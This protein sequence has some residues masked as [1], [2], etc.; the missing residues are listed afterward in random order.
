MQTATFAQ[1][2][3][4]GRSRRIRTL[5][6]WNAP[7]EWYWLPITASKIRAAARKIARELKPEKIIL[8]G[9]YAYGKPT[10]D[11]D[12]DLFVVMES[13]E[14]WTKRH[15]QVSEVL[16][17]RPFPVDIIVRTPMEVRERLQMDDCF[18]KEILGKGIVLYEREPNRGMD[19][20]SRRQL[21]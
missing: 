16:S 12:V 2:T 8:F 11:S 4:N 21:H 5:R 17:P 19:Q 3:N 13:D 10:E 6:K 20:K 18:I 15:I 14:R 7:K 9:S 1:T